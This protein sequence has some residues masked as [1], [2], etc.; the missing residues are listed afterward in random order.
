MIYRSRE[1]RAPLT[2]W[3]RFG[4]YGGGEFH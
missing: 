4:D 3:W 1:E 2:K